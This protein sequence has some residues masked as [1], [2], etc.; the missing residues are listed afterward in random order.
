MP[1]STAAPSI[2]GER[3]RAAATLSSIRST[4]RRAAIQLNAAAKA[5]RPSQ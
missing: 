2:A 5:G 3:I 4:N 1:F